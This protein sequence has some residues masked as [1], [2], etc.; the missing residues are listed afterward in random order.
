MKSLFLILLLSSA[1]WAWAE[2][3]PYMIYRSSGP[4][5]YVE[6]SEW[7]VKMGTQTYTLDEFVSGGK[8]CA[9]RGKHEFVGAIVLENGKIIKD[10]AHCSICGRKQFKTRKEAEEWEP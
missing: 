1:K 4:L 2:E 5:H 9:W 3:R 6:Y 10:S 7:V 8:F